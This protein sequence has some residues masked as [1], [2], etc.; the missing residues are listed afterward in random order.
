MNV[1]SMEMWLAATIYVKAKNARQ[2]KKLAKAWAEDTYEFSADEVQ[3]SDKSFS[4]PD[5]P[6]V[7]LSPAMTGWGFVG[8]KRATPALAEE[9]VPDG[10]GEED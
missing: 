1:Y 3:I 2:A 10:E 7:S 8:G 5:L 6:E 4:N 9:N